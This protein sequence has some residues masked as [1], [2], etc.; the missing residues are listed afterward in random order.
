[1]KF[2]ADFVTNSSSSSYVVVRIE[3]LKN[4]YAFN[5]EVE[6]DDLGKKKVLDKIFNSQ[7]ITSLLKIFDVTEDDLIYTEKLNKENP[8]T[9]S[10]N[11]LKIE[12]IA[13]IRYVS[14]YT[15]YGEEAYEYTEDLSEDE[16]ANL[17]KTSENDIL[18]INEIRVFDFKEKKTYLDQ[19][20]NI[21]IP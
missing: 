16:I 2:R 8:E 20:R 5:M 10:V 11:D 1:M 3:T 19:I 13:N 21:D 17:L 7:D 18:E 15:M 4:A 14:G 9:P 12:D 6:N